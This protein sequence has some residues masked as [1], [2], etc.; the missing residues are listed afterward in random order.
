MADAE[1]GQPISYEALAVRTPVLA[2]S[3]AELGTVAH[4]LLDDHLDLFDGIVVHTHDGIRFIDRDQIDAITTTAVTTTLS[5][6][7]VEALPKPDGEPIYEV[8]SLQGVGPSLTA[9]LRKLFGRQ[10]WTRTD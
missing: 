7:Q 1:A 3:G 6:E 8:D 4:V 2:A 10:Q 9:H 5:G